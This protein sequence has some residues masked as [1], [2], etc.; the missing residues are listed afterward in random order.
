MSKVSA[1][2]PGDA[3]ARGDD[4]RG[5]PLRTAERSRHVFTQDECIDRLVRDPDI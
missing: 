2:P 1:S 3:A 4:L 5:G